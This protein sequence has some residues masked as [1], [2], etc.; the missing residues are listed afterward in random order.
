MSKLIRRFSSRRERLDTS[1]LSE[2]LQGALAYDRIAGYFTSGILEVAGEALE[3]VEGVVRVVC[4]SHLDPRDVEAARAAANA[5]MRREWCASEPEKFGG[6]AS[7]R[8]A[9]L[10]DLLHSGKLV[11]RVL[12]DEKFGLIHGKAGV[13]TLADGQRTTFLGSVNETH[14]AWK[15]NYELLWED[16]CEE[17]ADWVQEEFDALWD[18]PFAVPLAEFVIEDIGRI[19]R[20]TV[21]PDVNEWRAAPNPAS[22]VVE[23][24]VYRREYGLWAHQK[25][26]VKRAFDAHLHGGAR[27]V[28]AD[29]VGLGK[30]VQLALSAMLMALYGD[31]PVLVLAPKAL[32]LQ[33]QDELR[34]LLDLPSAVWTGRKLDR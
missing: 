5:G 15:I 27:F 26:F 25:Y 29:Q 21:V 10:H 1:F 28:L 31:R 9:H 18:S 22:P 34:D 23:S 19:A 7:G 12:P 8:F 30:T 32:L 13:I 16:P 33:W 2:R 17:A 6:P 3:K 14:N 24:P 4:N 11:V 20:R